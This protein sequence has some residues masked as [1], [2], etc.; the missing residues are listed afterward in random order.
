MCNPWNGTADTYLAGWTLPVTEVHTQAC[1]HVALPADLSSPDTNSSPLKL[2]IKT[3]V[4]MQ[5]P[6]NH[7]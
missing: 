6:S 4:H 2:R 5:R 1:G 7:S 3:I